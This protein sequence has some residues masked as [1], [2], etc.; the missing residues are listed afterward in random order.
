MKKKAKE[1]MQEPDYKS[2]VG[3]QIPLQE[4]RRRRKSD[5]QSM[6]LMSIATEESCG[7]KNLKIML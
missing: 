3:R 4:H 1:R 6:A 7:E 5:K 2:S